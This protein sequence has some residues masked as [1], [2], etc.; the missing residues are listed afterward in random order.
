M[1]KTKIFIIGMLTG[2]QF[3]D[4]VKTLAVGVVVIL[5]AYGA[6]NSGYSLQL[7][8]DGVKVSLSPENQM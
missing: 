2:D 3:V 5:L 4:I 6:Y 8:K 1:N 7:S